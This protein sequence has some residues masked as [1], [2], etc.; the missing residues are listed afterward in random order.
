MRASYIRRQR[1]KPRPISKKPWLNKSAPPKPRKP[2]KKM[3][4]ARRTEQQ[5]YFASFPEWVSKPENSRCAVCIVLHAAGEQPH[6]DLT[7]ERHHAR[8]RHGKLLNWEPGWVG[9]CRFHRDWPHDPANRVRAEEH[10]IISTRTDW[11]TYP[12]EIRN[13]A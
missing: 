10:G 5:H 2:M 4:K 1:E 9:T 3:A 7:T 6:V 13:A 11:N 12:P 8:G